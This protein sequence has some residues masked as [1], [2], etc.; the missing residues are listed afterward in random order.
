MFSVRTAARAALIAGTFACAGLASAQ[1][2]R[3]VGP[4]GKVTFSDRP[5]VDAKATPETPRWFNV[6]VKLAKKTRL[7]PLTEIRGYPELAAMRILQKGNRL[8]ITPV[9]P[10]EYAFIVKHL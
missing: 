2:Y 7:M 8:S 4:D 1:V 10:K 6:D 9:D 3:I 5:P